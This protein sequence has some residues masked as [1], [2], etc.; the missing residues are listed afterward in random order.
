M[1]KIIEGL[2]RKDSELRH[3]QTEEEFAKG[4]QTSV[5]KR[6]S[7]PKKQGDRYIDINI[8]TNIR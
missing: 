1:S 6:A 3:H 7:H 8:N 5:G 4:A 2:A